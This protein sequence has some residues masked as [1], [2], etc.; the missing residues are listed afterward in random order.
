V[1]YNFQIE[2]NKMKLHMEYESVTQQ[3]LFCNGVLA[4][5]MSG[6]EYDVIAQNGY[7]SRESSVRA[8][9]FQKQCPLSKRNVVT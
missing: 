8:L 9:V 3:I 2:N 1:A 5:L 7:C 6:T 4:A